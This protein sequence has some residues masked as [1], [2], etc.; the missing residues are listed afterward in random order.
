MTALQVV[1]SLLEDGMCQ[2]KNGAGDLLQGS[3]RK[4]DTYVSTQHVM[5]TDKKQVVLLG[6][7]SFQHK[8]C[9]KKGWSLH[10]KGLRFQILLY[11]SQ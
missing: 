2:L 8:I 6:N 5:Q 10:A 3:R 9:H 4:S 1:M 11:R 7:Q